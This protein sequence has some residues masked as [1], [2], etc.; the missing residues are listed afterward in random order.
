MMVG[1]ISV[2]AN[3]YTCPTANY[4]DVQNT[5]NNTVNGDTII[6]PPGVV[7]WSSTLFVPDDITILGSGVGITV[8]KDE[9]SRSSGLGD[10]FE[11]HPN[12]SGL[13]RLSNLSISGG[14]T[15]TTVLFH[16]AVI[17]SGSCYKFRIDHCYFT[18]L[19]NINVSISTNVTGVFDH[20]T[21]FELNF[22]SGISV[23]N[24]AMQGGNGL[25]GDGLW[26]STI[27]Y[28]AVSNFFYI[29]NNIFDYEA[30]NNAMLGLED[31][32]AG[33]EVC[34]RYNSCTNWYVQ[35][36]GTE[37]SARFRSGRA[38]EIYENVFT[39]TPSQSRDGAFLFLRGG[40]ALVFSNTITGY[41]GN[42][43]AFWSLENDRS[44]E[45][46]A[47]WGSANGLNLWDSN[48]LVAAVSGSF[49]GTSGSTTMIDNSKTWSV[50]QWFGY[51]IRNLNQVN[52]NGCAACPL[53]IFGPGTNTST[54][55]TIS[56]NSVNQ[57]FT[58]PSHLGIPI[59]W[60]NGNNYGIYKVF[61]NL[62]QIGR[63][64]GDL[65]LDT[66]QGSGI[67]VN[68]ITGQ[69]TWPREASEPVYQWG[70]TLNGSPNYTYG[71]NNFGYNIIQNLD[72][73][74]NTPKPGYTP[75]ALPY[76]LT[77]LGVGTP[78]PGILTGWTH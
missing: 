20:N 46:F 77:T 50:N 3:T 27:N 58:L 16:G 2:Y 53:S 49:T 65:V 9:E 40:T 60:T 37:T 34:V 56:T 25:W 51:E 26:A 12:I 78:V 14:V 28:G 62:D 61:A 66:V 48:A 18:N 33:S 47:P 42:P 70:N 24:G 19:Y 15:N 8:I 54:F 5:V 57:I 39:Q 35:D 59:L 43:S 74:E 32:F 64:K 23:D 72:Y 67:P 63:G 6:I 31:S 4:Q 30:N 7:S 73:I 71:A 29:E 44:T 22:T 11:F 17:V 21:V 36:H 52:T 69:P 68:S 55:A 75:L 38:L 45:I 10:V 76:P 1:G 13:C 41:F